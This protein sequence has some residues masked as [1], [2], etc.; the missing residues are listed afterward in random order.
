M[1]AERRRTILLADDSS[2]VR[3]VVEV[4][5][6]QEPYEVHSVSDGEQAIHEVESLR[7]DMV[8]AD[9]FMPKKDGYDVCAFIQS[10]PELKHI[11]V[12]LLSG[13]FESFDQARAAKVGGDGHLVKPFEPRALV[14]KI[15]QLVGP[16]AG[17]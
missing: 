9:V 3:A 10:K 16:A 8:I 17:A 15:R 5:L 14:T 4:A 6:S 1:A 2:T 11:P 12:V 7:P 13:A